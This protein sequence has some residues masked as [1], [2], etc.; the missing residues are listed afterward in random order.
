MDGMG[1]LRRE[2]IGRVLFKFIDATV[3]VTVTSR[4]LPNVISDRVTVVLTNWQYP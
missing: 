3:T 4:G 2:S 1:R